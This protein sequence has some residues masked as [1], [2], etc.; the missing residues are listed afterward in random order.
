MTTHCA[1]AVII[2]LLPLAAGCDHAAP[3]AA[4]P[5]SSPAI[6]APAPE[7]IKPQLDAMEKAKGVEQVLQQGESA[8]REQSEGK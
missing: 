6:V 5:A 8:R 4:Q 7:I 3:P 2:A 1:S